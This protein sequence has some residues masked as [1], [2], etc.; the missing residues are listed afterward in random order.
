MVQIKAVEKDDL[1]R[2][3]VWWARCCACF[4]GV[5]RA[6]AE[7]RGVKSSFTIALIFITSRR[8]SASASKNRGTEKGDLIGLAR[9]LRRGAPFPLS[10]SSHVAIF[11]HY[12]RPVTLTPSLT[13]SLTLSRSLSHTPFFPLSFSLSLSL[14][15]SL[16][17]PRNGRFAAQA[18]AVAGGMALGRLMDKHF[19]Y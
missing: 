18:T 19:P 2:S 10:R 4:L 15:L 14:S 7:V 13:L 1:L 17:T 12:L 6:A 16:S 11:A 5:A 8:I 3:G 9:P